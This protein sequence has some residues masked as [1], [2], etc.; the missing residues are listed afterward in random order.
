MVAIVSH[1]EKAIFVTDNSSS[2]T[3]KLVGECA[4]KV[5]VWIVDP[6]KIA[7][8][9]LTDGSVALSINGNTC[10]IVECPATIAGDRSSLGCENLNAVGTTG[11]NSKLSLMIKDQ[12]PGVMLT[13][14]GAGK[15][16]VFI[17][18]LDMIVVVVSYEN[19]SIWVNTDTTKTEEL[20][21]PLSTA[22]KLGN[23]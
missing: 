21:L 5:V 13:G 8:T 3:T 11:N 7:A 19:L 20:S 17:E 2:T 9:I 10:R 16:V 4:N 6:E 12:S 22:A 23:E 15:A 18:H 1:P 14:E